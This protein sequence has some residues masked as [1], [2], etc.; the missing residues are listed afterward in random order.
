MSSY[1]RNPDAACANAIVRGIDEANKKYARWSGGDWLNDAGI[2]CLMSATVAEAIHDALPKSRLVHLEGKFGFFYG[3]IEAERRRADIL[4]TDV[5]NEPIHHVELK[6]T[7]NRDGI[8]HDL[9]KCQ[10]VF[11]F[12]DDLK[13]A[14]FG[15][16]VCWY[17]SAQKGSLEAEIKKQKSKINEIAEKTLHKSIATSWRS[18]RIDTTVWE[19][20]KW[21]AAAL[22]LTMT[23]K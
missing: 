6:R 1:K 3:G 23:R 12:S 4:I 21:E 2:E 10:D 16:F 11:D 7:L 13:S 9:E 5:D 22:V 19:T 14:H 18:K 8:E 20:Q 15:S 17:E